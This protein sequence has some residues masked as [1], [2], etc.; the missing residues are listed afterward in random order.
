[1][2]DSQN[3]IR[4]TKGDLQSQGVNEYVETQQ[5]LTRDMDDSPDQPWL[6]RIIYANW[7]YLSFAAGLG[8]LCGWAILEP[9]F[10]DDPLAED[11]VA[12]LLMFPVV[13]G[14]VDPHRHRLHAHRQHCPAAAGR[15]AR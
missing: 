9:F 13:A 12:A 11:T 4:I 15:T 2:P 8:G 3:P 5:W 6:I 1:V 14:G 7:F 10:S